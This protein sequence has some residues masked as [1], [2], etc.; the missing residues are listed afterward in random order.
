M[1]PRPRIV[2]DT[3][4][5]VSADLFEDSVPATALWLAL[6][7]GSLLMSEALI[8]ELR[9][10][11]SKP[12][13]DRYA[14]RAEREEFLRDLTR[15]T[16]TVEITEPVQACRDPDDDKILEL[17]V[18]G[19]ADYIVTGDDDLLVMNPFRGIPIIRPAEFLAF[20]GAEQE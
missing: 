18:N 4:V 12:R 7:L 8:E 19:R 3:N 9:M 10:V 6:D 2:F 1:T 15:E 5:I 11:L 14:T 16:E 20:V 17:A 13:F